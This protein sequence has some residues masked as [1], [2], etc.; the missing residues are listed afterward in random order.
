[1]L[2]LRPLLGYISFYKT[3]LT[4]KKKL[5]ISFFGIRGIGSVFYLSYAIKHGN[6]QDANQLYSI[7]ALVILISIILHG[8]TA[9]RMINAFDDIEKKNS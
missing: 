6:F 8:F 2:I 4:P 5:A 7:V 9:K 1:M 3:D